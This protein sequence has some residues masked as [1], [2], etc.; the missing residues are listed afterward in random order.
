[1]TPRE[2]VQTVSGRYVTVSCKGCG[3]MRTFHRNDLAL[4]AFKLCGGRYDGAR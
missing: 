3:D 1:M 4:A 2:F